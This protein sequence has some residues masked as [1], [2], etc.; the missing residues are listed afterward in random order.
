MELWYHHHNFYFK[1][2]AESQIES[3]MEKNDKLFNSISRACLDMS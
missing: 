3:F 2:F 1:W